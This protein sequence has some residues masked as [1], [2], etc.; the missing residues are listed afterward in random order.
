MRKISPMIAMIT[1]LIAF[2][3]IE[4]SRYEMPIPTLQNA[5]IAI[6]GLGY[7]GLPLAVAFSK[8]Y[9]TIGFDIDKSRIDELDSA[10]DSTQQVSSQDLQN[11]TNLSFTHKL[12]QITKA[13]I[14]II[15][16][17]TP[18]TE[19]KTPNLSALLHASELVG[20]V[21]QKG[22]IVIYESTT[23]PTCTENEC[24]NALEKSSNLVFNTDFYLGY[25]PE[26]INPSDS[27]HTLTQIQKIT[28]GSTQEVATFIDSLY[29]SIITA[30]T[31]CVSS[32]KTAEMTKIIE[33]AQRDLNIAFI[34]EMYMICD[35]LQIDA[36]EVLEA[37]KT[38]WNFLPFTP[39]LVG[40]HCISV[41]PY[42]LT[43]KLNSIGYHPQVISSG[44]LINDTMPHFI[45]HK[46]IKLM[47]QSD[48]EILNAKVLILGI[49]F[50]QNC[51][52]I[53]NSK[54]PIVKKELESFGVRVSV[55]DPMADK[56]EVQKMYHISLLDELPLA[57]FDCIFLAVAHDKL[58]CLNRKKLG[59]VKSVYY[60]LTSH[61]LDS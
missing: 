46:I 48:I 10:F 28:S 18:I 11:C 13:N 23:Y 37:A 41:D 6:I 15:C 9:P 42:Y 57:Y 53:R 32:I 22:N 29:G 19:N 1:P 21:L 52:D 34:N 38:K 45:A 55:Y 35:V 2:I 30:G 56:Q 39:G 17:P 5:H 44:R 14:Y 7:V 51:P 40:G 4:S 20:K 60:T 8:A 12:S 24:K 59:K 50:K 54:V 27:S 31:F 25:S 36:L 16:V 61:K 58:L 26:R 3:T 33:N 43:H 49:T 47:L